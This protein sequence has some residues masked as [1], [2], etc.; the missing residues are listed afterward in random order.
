MGERAE[1]PRGLSTE[2]SRRWRLKIVYL[3]MIEE[4][5]PLYEDCWFSSS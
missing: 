3:S 2:C 5:I 1:R 4:D